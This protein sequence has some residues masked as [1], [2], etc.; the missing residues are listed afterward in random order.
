[1][2]S[3]AQRSESYLTSQMNTF[4]TTPVF[5]VSDLPFFV[6]RDFGTALMRR[7]RKE[8]SAV[9]ASIEVTDRYPKGKRALKTLAMAIDNYLKKKGIWDS[10][11]VSNNH[12]HTP[13]GGSQLL[14]ILLYSKIDDRFD[15]VS[16]EGAS[17]PAA[18]GT[19]F[20]KR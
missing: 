4:G 1:M 3:V 6:L 17:T 10:N 5:G 8:Q 12:S 13:N 15:M 16:L 14:T 11:T 19:P 9:G 20:R 18:N 2:K 7:E